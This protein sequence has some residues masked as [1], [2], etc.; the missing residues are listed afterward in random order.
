MIDRSLE[1]QY[2]PIDR[3]L[4]YAKNARTHTDEQVAQ[5]AASIKEF[6]WT[7]PILVGRDGVIIAGHAR[8]AAARKLGI[9][10]VP[11][12]LLDHLS[13]TQRRALVLADN[14]L[15]ENAGW[16]EALLAEELRDID[17]DGFD[18][19]TV[20]FAA[21]ELE[22]LLAEPEQPESAPDVTEQIPEAPSQP[23]T[24]PGD[25]WQIGPHRLVCGDCRELAVVKELLAGGHAN[26]VITSPPYASQRAYDPA[27][28]FKPIRPEEYT[29]WF[30]P[31][32]ANIAAVLADHGS[33]FLNIAPHAEYGE[34]SLYVMDLI[35]THRRQWEWRLTDVLCWRKT[36]DGVPGGWGNRFKSAWEPVYHLCREPKIKCKRLSNRIWFRPLPGDELGG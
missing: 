27:S 26:V 9:A 11:V 15:A 8:L 7:N 3:L 5:V 4:P 35:I 24:K 17:T 14:R 33:F 21:D 29:D 34:R 16:D 13:E 6:G 30:R 19:A 10:E 25:I 32:A 18:L 20:G 22:A 28:G 1:I 2:W 23:I 36:D 31:V 12:I